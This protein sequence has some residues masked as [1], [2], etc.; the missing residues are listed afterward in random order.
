MITQTSRYALRAAL[1]IAERGDVRPVKVKEISEELGV[2]Q[3]YLSKILHRLVGSGLLRSTRGPTGGFQFNKSPS[4]I[5]L[6]S[7]IGEL[8]VS[9]A[10]GAR[11]RCLL[12]LPVCSDKTPCTAHGKWC[13]IAAAYEEFFEQTTLDDLLRRGSSPP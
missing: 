11:R 13:K 6:S 8:E 5:S 9:E 4:E 1:L 3:N 12:G 7:L 2:P 10:G